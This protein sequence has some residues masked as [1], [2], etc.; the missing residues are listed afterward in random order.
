[1]SE[2]VDNTEKNNF[3]LIEEDA[4]CQD[5]MR[6]HPD[7]FDELQWNE[8]NLKERLEK[9]PYQYQQYRML[10]LKEKHNLRKIE[11]L[12]EEYI[13]QLYDSLK[14]GGEKKLTKSEIEKY[15]IPKD[16]KVKAFRVRFMKQQIRAEIYEHIA[17][18][19]KNQGFE[20]NA[21]V[22]ALDV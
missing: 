21:Y 15:Y 3:D 7:L 10:W 17:I 9:N 1:M 20:L 22:K 12:M 4:I 18:S 6:Q 14:Y 5:V 19:F 2:P 11:I 8:Y 16:D 13:G